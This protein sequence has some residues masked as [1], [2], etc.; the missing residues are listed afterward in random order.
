[1]DSPGATAVKP[2]ARP[3]KRKLADLHASATPPPAPV[4]SS[5]LA[6]A[7]QL[8]PPPFN[9]PPGFFL[10]RGHPINKP[11]FRYVACGPSPGSSPTYPLYRI[12]PSP[13]E[14]RVR[15]SWEDRSQLLAV[16]DDA[17]AVTADKGYRSARANVPLREGN[18]YFEV[19]VERGGGDPGAWKG[20]G[21]HVRLGVGRRESP[22]TAPVGFDGYSYGVRDKT[23]EAVTLSQPKAY[24][25]P[26]GTGDVI[27]VLIS[28]PPRRAADEEDDSDPAHLRRKRVPIRYKG[29]LYFESLEYPATREMGEVFDLLANKGVKKAAP[30]VKAAAPGTKAPVAPVVLPAR[31]LP[32]LPGSRLE[33]YKNGEPLGV[34]FED[35]YDFLPLRPHPRPRNAR[36]PAPGS[37]AA[38]EN[39]HDDGSLGYYPFVSVFG[40]GIARLNAGPAFRFPVA[41]PTLPVRAL[42]ERYDEYVAETVALDERDEVDLRRAIDVEVV[43]AAKRANKA[44]GG[45]KPA[46]PIKRGS[47]TVTAAPSPA[48]SAS[49]PTVG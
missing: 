6:L 34:A 4:D 7:P 27:G 15:F 35:L 12:I 28:L 44:A 40:G 43:E 46:A 29:Q 31:P 26:F 36:P 17:L 37:D 13:P 2:A 42:H 1:V 45:G 21:C 30:K 11:N 14:G 32:T 8:I 18:W 38:R 47:T 5:T 3:T 20:G 9:S 24:G 41:H 39:H 25:T 48:G 16:S 33:F 23:G 10:T 22:L 49:P 19:T